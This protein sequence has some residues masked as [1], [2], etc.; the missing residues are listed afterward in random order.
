MLPRPGDVV[1]VGSAASVQFGGDRA[2]TVRVIRVDPRPTY[3]G[4]AW[5]DAYALGPDGYA[6]VRRSIYVQVAGLRHVP[7]VSC[8]S[9]SQVLNGGRRGG[10]DLPR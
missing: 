1:F 5:L 7:D 2:I 6:M 4:Y 3:A 8:G 10:L 9:I